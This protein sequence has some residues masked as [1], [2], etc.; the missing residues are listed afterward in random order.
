MEM[1]EPTESEHKHR[2]ISGWILLTPSTS[3]FFTLQV[4]ASH[5]HKS[6]GVKTHKACISTTPRA[7]PLKALGGTRTHDTLEF[8][9]PLTSYQQAGLKVCNTTQHNTEQKQ[10]PNSVLCHRSLCCSNRTRLLSLA[11][12]NRKDCRWL[13][14]YTRRLAINACAV[15]SSRRLIT[16]HRFQTLLLGL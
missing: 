8:Y 12:S 13:F 4:K 14:I 15:G 2:Q 3:A 10:T 5:R 6:G 7:T 1:S 16:L 9:V 11:A